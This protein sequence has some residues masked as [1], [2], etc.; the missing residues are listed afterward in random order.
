M[1]Y[2]CPGKFIY[3]AHPHT[4]S[5]GTIQV[6]R[7]WQRD[8][9]PGRE[10]KPHHIRLSKLIAQVQ[11]EPDLPDVSDELTWTVVRNPYDLFVSMW[12]RKRGVTKKDFRTFCL[13]W[14]STPYI[15]DGMLYFHASDAQRV[16]RYENLV[17][18]LED[19]CR[20]FGIP[21]IVPTRVNVTGGKEDWRM[22]VTDDILSILNRRFGDEFE[23][24]YPVVEKVDDL[25]T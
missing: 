6:L 2:V 1:A 18:E 12:F 3:L 17:P 20:F 7:R 22:Y 21:A 11:I 24:F 9:F 23:R 13:D 4:A 8:G 5:S 15:E 16:L 25:G 10:I 19:L 14:R